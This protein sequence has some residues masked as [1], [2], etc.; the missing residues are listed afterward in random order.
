MRALASSATSSQWSGCPLTAVT[1]P[2]RISV[3]SLKVAEL[4]NFTGDTVGEGA[5]QARH[6]IHRVC[7]RDSLVGFLAHTGL[8]LYDEPSP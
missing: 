1:K 3:G 8:S 5:D 7:D 6:G 4:A 2:G